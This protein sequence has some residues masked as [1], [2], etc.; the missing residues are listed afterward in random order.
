M[1]QIGGTTG[2]GRCSAALRSRH[3]RYGHA[4]L[5]REVDDA[6]AL[7]A[8]E[9]GGDHDESLAAL[10][11]RR[12]KGRVDVRGASSLQGLKLDTR[13]LGG[14]M[15]LPE[16]GMR[17]LWV[18]QDADSA[19]IGPSDAHTSRVRSGPRSP[20]ATSISAGLKG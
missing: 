1:G 17:V 10:A 14:E 7:E 5:C 8:H 16:L 6:L 2:K 19:S 3:P 12:L 9:P 13:S 4:T 20:S 18:P 15:V 11:T